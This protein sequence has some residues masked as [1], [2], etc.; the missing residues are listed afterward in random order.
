MPVQTANSKT[1]PTKQSNREDK[2]AA[3]I[4]VHLHDSAKIERLREREI[5]DWQILIKLK[6]LRGLEKLTN[7]IIK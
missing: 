2:Q 6:I 1:K 4:T 3:N 7:Y 5:G